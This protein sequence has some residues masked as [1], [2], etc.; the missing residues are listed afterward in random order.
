[1][2]QRGTLVDVGFGRVGVGPGHARA[3]GGFRV[4]HTGAGAAAGAAEV[5]ILQA[6]RNLGS[7]RPLPLADGEVP[8]PL[9]HSA[10]L[11]WV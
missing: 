4:E 8:L 3:P 9:N 6:M 2:C 10:I 5:H 1:M 7:E 11:W